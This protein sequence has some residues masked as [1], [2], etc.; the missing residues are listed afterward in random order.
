MFD[1]K[2]HAS[3]VFK[4]QSFQDCAKV[5]GDRGVGDLCLTARRIWLLNVLPIIPSFLRRFIPVGHFGGSESDIRKG[6]GRRGC[7]HQD[8]NSCRR[9]GRQAT[10]WE[11]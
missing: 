8:C 3:N 6:T 11:S 10:A 5:L 2:Q 9:N 4:L 7:K 1:L